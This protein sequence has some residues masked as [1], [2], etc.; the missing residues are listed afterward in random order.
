MNRRKFIKTGLQVGGAGLMASTLGCQG[1]LFDAF[2]QTADEAIVIEAVGSQCIYRVNLNTGATSVISDGVIFGGNQLG[3]IALL[4][5][6]TAL[7]TT[8]TTTGGTLYKVDLN[9]NTVQLLVSGFSPGNTSDCIAV[10][11]RNSVLIGASGTLYRM[12]LRTLTVTKTQAIGTALHGIALESESS[13]LIIENNDSLHRVNLADF[14]FSTLMATTTGNNGRDVAIALDRNLAMVVANAGGIQI[15]RI[16]LS[17]NTALSTLGALTNGA[18][19]GIALEN[20]SSTL[21]GDNTSGGLYRVDLDTGVTSRVDDGTLNSI[22][23][24][25]IAVR[26]Q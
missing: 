10:E 23:I 6:D 22:L 3:G 13:A 4:D 1:S 9:A 5:E 21:V 8:G 18:G 16:N 12:N 20:G 2:G 7:V 15:V 11:N 19:K 14:S 25:K 17:S 24:R 26:F